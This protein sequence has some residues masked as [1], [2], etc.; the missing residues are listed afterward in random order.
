MSQSFDN[1]TP[2][3]YSQG[4]T[5]R[6]RQLFMTLEVLGISWKNTFSFACLCWVKPCWGACFFQT[7]RPNKQIRHQ[8]QQFV[9]HKQYYIILLSAWNKSDSHSYSASIGHLST[10]KKLVLYPVRLNFNIS[11][12]HTGWDEC[13]TS[14]KLVDKSMNFKPQKAMF[15]NKKTGIQQGTCSTVINKRTTLFYPSLHRGDVSSSFKFR[16]KAPRGRFDTCGVTRHIR[17]NTITSANLFPSQEVR[18]NLSK[19]SEKDMRG[20]LNTHK[21]W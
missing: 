8:I 2:N 1:H 11:S 19:W 3:P 4:M 21:V 12:T 14:T 18:A 20:F 10:V 16:A 9:K 5:G 17:E 13:P 6:L 7:N 15:I